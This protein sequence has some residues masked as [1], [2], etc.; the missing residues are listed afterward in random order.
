MSVRF[1]ASISLVIQLFISLSFV[2]ALDSAN[3]GMSTSKILHTHV[4]PKKIPNA[5][6]LCLNSGTH[7]VHEALIKKEK[8]TCISITLS[9]T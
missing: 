8:Y 3:T 7:K 5:R 6:L 2:Q 1:I 9:L 4:C